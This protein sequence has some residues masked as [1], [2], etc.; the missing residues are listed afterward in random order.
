M[1]RLY[2][3]AVQCFGEGELRTKI[4]EM[5]MEAVEDESLGREV[6]VSDENMLSFFCGIWIQFLLVEVAG[7]KKENLR[8]MAQK[9][10]MDFQENKS[11]H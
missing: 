6:Y 2:H 7:I 3:R 11:L 10:F 8:A 1:E 4:L 9:V 5:A